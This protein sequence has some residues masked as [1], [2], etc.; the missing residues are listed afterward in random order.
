MCGLMRIKE[1]LRRLY[2]VFS[3]GLSQVKLD[4]GLSYHGHD[5]DYSGTLLR[6]IPDANM[7]FQAPE[8]LG[9]FPAT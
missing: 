3:A 2:C 1:K 4:F 5:K 7:T 9:F 6:L 8:E